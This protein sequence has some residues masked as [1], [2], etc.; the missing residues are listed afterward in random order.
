MNLGTG[1]KATQFN[2]LEQINRIFGTVYSTWTSL[3]NPD[4]G[5]KFTVEGI[6]AAERQNRKYKISATQFFQSS[7]HRIGIIQKYA[8]RKFLEML[9]TVSEKK[10]LFPGL[11]PNDVLLLSSYL[12]NIYRAI[13]GSIILHIKYI[14]QHTDS[15]QS[16]SAWPSFCDCYAFICL[17]IQ[18]IR[19]YTK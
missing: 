3:L 18:N 14:V 19:L 17:V 1:N 10:S 8:N 11:F 16:L 2:F 5:M 4:F 13:K 15:C 12:P 9:N 7:F 6:P